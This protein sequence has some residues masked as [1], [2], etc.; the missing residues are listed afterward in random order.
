M[1]KVKLDFLSKEEAD[2]IHE[3]SIEMLG[4]FGVLIRSDSVLDLLAENGA[5]VDRVKK[6]ARIPENIVL[7]AIASAPKRF[8]LRARNRGNDV[9]LPA[10]G[11]PY[12]TTDGLTL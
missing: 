2:L 1:A 7:E 3:Q 6:V 5:K 9:E 10:S 8:V 11:L 12:L 4:T